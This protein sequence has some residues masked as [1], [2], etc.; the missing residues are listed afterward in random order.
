LD[1]PHHARSLLSAKR[2]MPKPISISGDSLVNIA[3]PGEHAEAVP[4]LITPAM[5]DVD[6]VAWAASARPRLEWLLSTHGALLFRGF[7]VRDADAFHQFARVLSDELLDYTERAAPRVTMRPQ[8]YTS[9]EFPAD[10]YIPFHHEMSY[11]HHWPGRIWFHCVQAAPQGGCTPISDDRKVFQRLRPEVKDLFLRKKLMYI[12]NFG[13]GV[14]LSWQEAFQTDSKAVVEKYC[15]DSGI[16]VEWLSDD[17]LRTRQI[18]QVTITHPKTGETIWFNHAHMFHWSS[19]EQATRQA[20]LSQFSDEE[21]P[22]NACFGDGSRIDPELLDDIRAAYEQNA[23]RFTWQ[24]GDVLML[25]N[26]L[27]SHA[28]DPYVGPRKI[29]V[30]MGDMCSAP[31][32]S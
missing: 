24:P 6:A 19:L 4:V 22:R 18:R 21:L 29:L 3:K 12:R 26:I 10:Q 13:L 11:S 17:R 14:D 9:T 30:A 20:L 15:Q 28:R 27:M 23:M 16:Q 32:P 5:K 8:V 7:S 31:R 1:T 2:A 25:D